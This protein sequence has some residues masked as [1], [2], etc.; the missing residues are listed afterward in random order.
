L[1]KNRQL[2]THWFSTSHWHK[3]QRNRED[4]G[5][6]ARVSLYPLPLQTALL[7]EGQTPVRWQKAIW[8]VPREIAADTPLIRSHEIKDGDE[9]G[10][11]T[12]SCPVP[13]NEQPDD[14][15]LF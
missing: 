8:V 14:V 9:F 3:L 2:L 10:V 4:P 11:S 6:K 15:E 7:A 13:V 5:A 12:Q 1:P